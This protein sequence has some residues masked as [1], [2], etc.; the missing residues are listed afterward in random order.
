MI[1]LDFRS[2]SRTENPTPSPS[3]VRNATPPKHLRLLTTPAQAPT[4]QP[5]WL[6]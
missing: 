2:R 1:Q 4:P 6:Q 3:V 5:C